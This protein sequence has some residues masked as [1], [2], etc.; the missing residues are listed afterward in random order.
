MRN[1][2]RKSSSSC[3]HAC[4]AVPAPGGGVAQA[5][6]AARTCPHHD[7]VSNQPA[8]S[9]GGGGWA[10]SRSAMSRSGSGPAGPGDERDSTVAGRRRRITAA[11]SY[12]TSHGRVGCCRELRGTDHDQPVRLGGLPAGR[13]GPRRSEDRSSPRRE[14]SRCSLRAWQPSARPAGRPGRV[15]RLR[16]T[17]VSRRPRVGKRASL[18]LLYPDEKAQA[19]VGPG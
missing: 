9:P 2:R 8:R 16:R 11:A 5:A 3:S 4:H 10:A 17:G 13:R 14:E 15:R 6:M 18:S 19:G 7:A 12:W 1:Q